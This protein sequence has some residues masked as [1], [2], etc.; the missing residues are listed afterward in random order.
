MKKSFK[1][2]YVKIL[3]ESS[4][5]LEVERKKVKD[6]YIKVLSISI[7]VMFLWL[8]IFHSLN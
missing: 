6:V 2:I 1:D 4:A 8:I 5:D 3:E 7:V